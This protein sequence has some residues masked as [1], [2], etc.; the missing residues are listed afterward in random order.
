MKNDIDLPI[1]NRNN[2]NKD[3]PEKSILFLPS[4]IVY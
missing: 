4:N 2:K 1:L 3:L